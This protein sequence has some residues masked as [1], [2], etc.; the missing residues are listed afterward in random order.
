MASLGIYGSHDATVCIVTDSGAVRNYEWERWCGQRYARLGKKSDQTHRAFYE[1]IKE[2]SGVD[3]I[4]AAYWQLVHESHRAVLTEIFSVQRWQWMPH[5]PAHAYGSFVQSGLDRALVVS[6]DGGGPDE[7]S[8]RRASFWK[9]FECSPGECLEVS[10]RLSNL[11]INYGMLAWPIKEIA[12]RG[13]RMTAFLQSAG[14][15]MGLSAYGKARPEWLEPV[16]KYLLQQGIGVNVVGLRILEGLFPIERDALEGTDAQ[17]LAATAQ[18]AFQKIVRE[19]I[20]TD[21]PI[22]LTGGC[23]MNVLGNE[24]IRRN[25]GPVYVPPAPG[26]CG[27]AYGMVALGEKLTAS[28][29]QQY[30]G[31]PILGKVPGGEGVVDLAERL[32]RG[33]IIGVMR[34]RSEHG[35]RALGNRSILCD[36]STPRIKERL[37][38]SVKFREWFRPYAPMCPLEVANE[39]FDFD[40]DSPY[41]SF[42]PVVRPQWRE[43]LAGI[44]HVDGTA[45]LQ[46]VTPEQNPW[47][48]ELLFK[49]G[50]I[51]GHACLL[52]TSL[53]I[54]GRPIVARA[55]DALEILDETALDALVIEDRIFEGA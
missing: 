7:R 6:I 26:D 48:H 11:G 12:K 22:I 52:N 5:H 4:D 51:T 45:R 37:N 20:G 31:L 2:D 3:S 13:D 55:A 34:G 44:T 53:N 41:M 36:P 23:A 49:F 42:A 38:E 43:R 32:A 27:L 29:P 14:K 30:S 15:L 39:Y 35:P 40:G 16:E 19:S 10:E 25:V 1:F 28:P 8:E 33:Q 21:L 47:L 46:T 24:D 17:D 54:R 18:V 9:V 50:A